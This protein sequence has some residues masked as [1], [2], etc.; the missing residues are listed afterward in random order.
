MSKRYGSIL[1]IRKSRTVSWTRYALTG[2]PSLLRALSNDLQTILSEFALPIACVRRLDKRA[3]KGPNFS[4][5]LQFIDDTESMIAEF[6]N[7]DASDRRAFA[8]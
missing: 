3:E 7:V 4:C 1:E 5:T 8:D 6:E 2:N